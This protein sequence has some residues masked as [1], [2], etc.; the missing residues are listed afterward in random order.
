M[1]SYTFLVLDIY[2]ILCV[3]IL[4]FDFVFDPLCSV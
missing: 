2:C 4:Y 3:N 1:F